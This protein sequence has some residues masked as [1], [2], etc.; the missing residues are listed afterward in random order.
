MPL[1]K[2]GFRRRTY[3]EIL[4]E[5]IEDTKNEFG[6]DVNT[7][8]NG[9]LGKLLRIEA[10]RYAKLEE[11]QEDTYYSA[12]KNTAEGV[13]LNRLS[14]YAGVRRL[15]AQYAEGPITIEGTPNYTV[16]I[17]FVVAT[18]Q[19]VFFQTIEP[20]TLDGNGTGSG[21]I[22]AQEF[23]AQANV[24]ANKVTVIVN[25]DA[26]VNSV[27]N[28]EP[29][30]NGREKE[31]DFEFRDRMDIAVEGLG[32]ATPPA[33]LSALLNTKGVRAATIINN[34]TLTTDS[35]NTP[36][37]SYQAFVLGGTDEDIFETILNNGPAG[38]EPYG[39][40]T[41]TATDLSGNQQ[42][43]GFSR[44]QEIRV[45]VC[46]TIQK[47]NAFPKDGP[48]RIRSELVRYIGGRDKSG[49]K[50]AGLNMTD[51]VTYNQLISRVLK[52]Q[53]IDDLSVEL[54]KDGSSYSTGNISIDVQEV[55]QCDSTDIEVTIN[56]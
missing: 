38:I 39:Q 41:G 44:A 11:E 5:M 35:Y 15:P 55:A 32:K 37:K 31:T 12:Y 1:S 30:A 54:S 29:T 40:V 53:G 20:I 25:P 22:T 9:T 21:A 49:S 13:Q 24:E 42:P 33:I 14:P 36:G 3:E 18:E 17:G 34:V 19:D 47:N 46:I 2:T 7:S 26:N 8:E 43:V 10:R 6:E 23:G 4:G 56:A 28:P 45:Y 52:I 51:D 48:D 27:S 16:P 50:Y